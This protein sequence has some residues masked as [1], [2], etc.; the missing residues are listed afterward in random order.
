MSRIGRMPIKI[1]G[2]VQVKVE[3]GQVTVQGPRGTLTQA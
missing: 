1:P 2:G 3:D